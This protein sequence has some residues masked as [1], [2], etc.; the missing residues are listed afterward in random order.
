MTPRPSEPA[1]VVDWDLPIEMDDGLVLRA[2]VFRPDDGEP[3]PAIVAYGPYAKGLTFPDGYPDA[4]RALVEAHPEVEAASSNRYQA[5]EV[6]DPERWVPDGYVCVRVDARGW[7]RSPGRIDPWSPRET[8]DLHDCIEWA[9]RQPWCSGT[10]GLLGISYYAINQWHVAGL[11][12]PHLAAMIPWE[13]FADSYRDLGYHGGIASDMK[14]VW[15]RRTITTVQHGLGE[16]SFRSSMTGELVTGPETLADEELAANRTDFVGDIDAHA[17]DHAWH[18]ERSADWGR[19][20][21][22][23]LSAGNWGGSSLHL[24]GNVE[25]FVQAA[26]EQKWLEIHG[27]EHWT[28]FYTDYGLE[29]QHRFFDHFLKGEDNGWDAQPRVMLRVRTVDGGFRDRT[30]HEWPIARTRWTTLHLDPAG[31][32][33]GPEPLDRERAASFAALEDPGIT[34]RTEPFEDETEI[35]GPVAATVF[36]SSSTTDADVFCVLRV[37]DPDG[38]EVVLQGAVDPHTP[39]GQGW[40]RASHRSLDVERSEPWRPW[41]P[42][43]EVHPLTPGEVVRLDV[44]IW[45]TSIVVPPGY[46]VGLSIRGTD[47][48]YEGSDG[49]AELSHFKGTKMRGVGIYTHADPVHRPPEI[50]GGT[51][52]VISGPDHPSTLL[53]PVIP[54]RTP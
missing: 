46:R 5:W 34:M 17:L 22:P 32:T 40:L 15:Y 4:W 26:S 1:I 53:L 8:R 52:T 14:K 36:V 12:P 25:A 47:Y 18:R 30:E 13:G 49:G 37:F 44:E 20:T 29:L 24:R 21:V 54:E 27:L 45:P 9:A 3:G 19:I 51:T 42:H 6:C 28:E 48:E 10:V 2:D 31:G 50:Y 43:D 35:T 38:E 23:F 11:Q 41:H 33:L 16:R 7:G 39:I